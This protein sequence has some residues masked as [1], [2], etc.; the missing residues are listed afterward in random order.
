MEVFMRSDIEG[1]E[2]RPLITHLDCEGETIELLRMDWFYSGVNVPQ[3]YST[4]CFSG[5]TKAWHRHLTQTD[6]MVCISG[7]ICFGFIEEREDD[8][9]SEEVVVRAERPILITVPPKVWHGFRNISS[10]TA[11]ILN[12]PDQLYNYARPDMERKEYEEFADY[13]SLGSNLG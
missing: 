12:A 2:Y 4:T 3:I 1:L 6:R 9:V 10:E 8:I 7:I 11:I 13:C 5:K